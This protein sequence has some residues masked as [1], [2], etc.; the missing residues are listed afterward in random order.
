MTRESRPG[1]RFFRQ[2]GGPARAAFLGALI[3]GLVAQGMGLFNKFSWHDDIFQLFGTGATI[4]SGRWMLQ[5][6]MEAEDL[7][8]GGHCSLPLL[9]GFFA[10]LCVGASAGLMVALLRIRRPPLCALLGAVMAAFPMVT[11]LFGFIFTAPAYS[12]ALLMITAGAYLLCAEGRWGWKIPGILLCVCSVGTYQ[13]FLPLLLSLLLLSDLRM[14]AEGERPPAALLRRM[15]GQGICLV[16]I[17]AL[18]LAGSRFFLRKYGL[19]LDTYMGINQAASTSPLVY[20]ERAG[21]AYREFFLPSRNVSWDMYPQHAHYLYLLMLCADGLMG[22]GL[23]FTA[24]RRSRGRGA[25]TLLLLALFPLGCNFIFVMSEE[26]HSLMTYGQVAQLALFV[27]LADRTELPRPRFRRL[28]PGLAALVMAGLGVMYARYDNQC[29]LKTAFQQQQAISWNTALVARIKSAKGYRDEL[30]VAWVNRTEA[31]D[32]TLYNIGELDFLRLSG[33]EYD[34]Q[35]YVNNWAWE[36]FLARWCGF[37]PETVDPETV[38]SRPEV[39]GMPAYPA[40]GSIQV[41]ED[42]VV[43]KF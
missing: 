1:K 35:T 40:D 42:V 19:V 28:I 5:V 38:S 15:A 33:Y 10:L 20:L 21:R 43:V 31:Q 9:H 6:L 25:L 39:E 17:M 41:L 36:R 29:Y 18:Y 37:A 27:W 8:F 30:P 13:A 3:G 24:W 2:P 26:V 11:A 7:L 34:I 32:R 16:L 23:A 14:L 22:L 4:T 12:L